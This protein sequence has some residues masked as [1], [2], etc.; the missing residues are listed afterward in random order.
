MLRGVCSLVSTNTTTSRKRLKVRELYS[1]KQIKY[2]VKRRRETNRRQVLRLRFC[3]KCITSLEIDNPTEKIREIR[4]RKRTTRI[5]EARI[6]AIS[7][8]RSALHFRTL[9][10]SLLFWYLSSMTFAD[11]ENRRSP[12]SRATRKKRVKKK[13]RQRACRRKDQRRTL[14]LA[15]RDSDSDSEKNLSRA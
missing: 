3:R 6:I 13:T 4:I 10:S 8:E 14:S 12:V 2:P 1:N 5:T 7:D 11:S 9:Y 15:H